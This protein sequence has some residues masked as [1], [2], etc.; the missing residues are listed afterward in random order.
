MAQIKI[1]TEKSGLHVWSHSVSVV[2]ALMFHVLPLA[3]ATEDCVFTICNDTS[4]T[5]DWLATHKIPFEVIDYECY[6][7]QEEGD[8]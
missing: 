6:G 3:S 8:C 7:H 2:I 4:S 1:N 5:I